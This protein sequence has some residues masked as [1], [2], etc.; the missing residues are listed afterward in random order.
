MNSVI[1]SLRLPRSPL[2]GARRKE[3]QLVLGQDP[4]AVLSF[5]PWVLSQ[6]ASR[7]ALRDGMPWIPFK[8][9][10]WL[11]ERLNAQTRAF[12][13]GSGGSTLF[14]SRRAREVVSV[15]HEP[16]WYASVQDSLVAGEHVNCHYRL[17]EP[18]RLAPGEVGVC[19][20]G[21]KRASGLDFEH[22][23]NVILEYPDSFFDLILIDGRARTACLRAAWR[24]VRIGGDILFDN[25]NYER[26][27]PELNG[28]SGFERFDIRGVSPYQGAIYTASTVWH[29]K[30]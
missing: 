28:P 27:Q 23:V 3:W 2:S 24:K 14:L 17:V 9:Q 6:G 4:L 16:C 8:A 30:Q 1:P 29:R 7:S 12:E 15:E 19:T 25:S 5:V 21:H 18:K 20:S 13:W 10:R 22:Y 26:Y 11:A